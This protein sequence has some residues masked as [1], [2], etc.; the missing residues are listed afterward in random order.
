MRLD[1]N[2]GALLV[3][4]L[5]LG[6][7]SWKVA[8]PFWSYLLLGLLIAALTF[9][10]FDRLRSWTG[11]PRISAGLTVTAVLAAVI[12]PLTM[13]AWQIVLDM[14]QFVR[15]LTIASV[16][17]KLQATLVW[18]HETV[19]YPTEVDPTTAQTLLADLIPQVRSGLANWIPSALAGVGT[20][21]IGISLSIII[22]YYALLTGESFVKKLKHAS[23]M[24][25][26]LEE[27]FLKETK[28]TVEG[29]VLG[30]V[31]TALIQGGLGYLAFFI[32]GIPNAF[33][34]SFV[35]AIL[36]FLPV[37]GAFLVWMPAAIFLFA[38][39]STGMGVFMVL[40]GTLVI[41]MIDNF[42]KPMV[43]G[44][45]AALHPMLAFVGVIGG[46]VAFGIMGFLMGPLVL[47]LLAVVFNVLAETRWD[48]DEW[49]PER[50]SAPDDE[51]G[52]AVVDEG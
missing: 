19:G 39:G 28:D 22:A 31:I 26:D 2:L 16:T 29:V 43:I 42:V 1:L 50:E 23:P 41:S 47:S 6:V 9:P 49:E 3:Y 33:F 45:S 11:R 7:L 36:S 25:D 21:M 12:V 5:V 8:A 48:I 34:W 46:L 14:T 15:G 35:M 32:A 4:G 52:E 51:A 20:F 17:E 13:L 30:Q 27:H 38:T 44:R 40:W 10:I 37:V 24:D 18:S